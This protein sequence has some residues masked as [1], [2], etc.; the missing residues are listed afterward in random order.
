MRR[1]PL[2]VCSILLLGMIV[3]GI[4]AT[5]ATKPQEAEQI[6][7]APNRDSAPGMTMKDMALRSAKI[8]T[9]RCLQTRS[10]WFGRTIYTLVTISVDETIK[11]DE[12]QTLMV[13]IPGGADATRRIPVAM[14]FPGAPKILRQEEVFLFLQP[15]DILPGSYSVM[16]YAQ[17]KLSIVADEN[18]EKLVTRNPAFPQPNRATGK[19]RGARLSEFKEQIRKYLR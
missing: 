11:G 19:I 18:S 8:V 3:S 14:T 13:A 2:A 17:G 4:W 6:F 15:A 7:E 16:G 10:A 1:F 12:S 5:R 9:G